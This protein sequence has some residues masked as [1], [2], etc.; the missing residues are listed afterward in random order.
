MS[1]VSPGWYPDPSG[2]FVQRYHD[3]ARWT[4]HVADASGNMATDTPAGQGGPGRAGGGAGPGR[5]AGWEQQQAQGWGREPGA[6]SLASPGVSGG[7]AGPG[8]QTD[9]DWL[10]SGQ[11]AG[12][13][14]GSGSAPGQPTSWGQGSPWG[15]GRQ[16]GSGPGGYGGQG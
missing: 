9:R 16:P 3:G 7:D 13:E 11:G 10:A 4:E 1:Q 6:G 15:E 5:S 12:W 2:R 14:S 8:W